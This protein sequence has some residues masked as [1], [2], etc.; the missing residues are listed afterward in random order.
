M[1]EKSVEFWNHNHNK[2]RMDKI[3]SSSAN[4]KILTNFL[5]IFDEQGKD[6]IF[7]IQTLTDVHSAL[8][9]HASIKLNPS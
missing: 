2:N 8:I 6:T 7:R 5:R 4:R 1:P 3:A 9:L